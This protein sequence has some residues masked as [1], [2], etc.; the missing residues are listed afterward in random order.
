[1]TLI[2]NSADGVEFLLDET[3]FTFFREFSRN[4]IIDNC[5]A[6]TRIVNT[7][8]IKFPQLRQRC[9]QQEMTLLLNELLELLE[10]SIGTH[11]AKTLLFEA[12]A[13]LEIEKK[14]MDRQNSTISG[15]DLTSDPTTLDQLPT[16]QLPLNEVTA[17][18]PQFNSTSN[19]NL[20]LVSNREA[21]SISNIPL[22]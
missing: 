14:K 21:S 13:K 20:E 19:S 3:N 10:H 9:L 12:A 4:N 17:S 8:C 2:S 22:L 16:D 6:V 7:V 5:D 15:L 11:A 1:M 18:S